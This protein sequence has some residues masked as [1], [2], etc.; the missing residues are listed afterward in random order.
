MIRDSLGKRHITP[1]YAH[2]RS[3]DIRHSLADV[4]KAREHLGYYPACNV[5]K[6]IQKVINSYRDI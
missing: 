2:F 4:G 6:G 5:S 1:N 3:G